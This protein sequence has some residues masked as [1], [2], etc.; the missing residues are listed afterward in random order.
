MV[1]VLVT[2]LCLILTSSW[3]VACQTPLSM[4]FSRQEHWSGL[5][6]LLQGIFL[7]QGSNPGL[8]HCRQILYCWSH[9]PL[10]INFMNQ[11]TCSQIC[12]DIPYKEAQEEFQ[13]KL[14]KFVAYQFIGNIF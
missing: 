8:L 5:H 4:E 3:T 13:T 11:Q 6:A 12:K 9:P 10:K 1:C 7:T 2:Q 14:L